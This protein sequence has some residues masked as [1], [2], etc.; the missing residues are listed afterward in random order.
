MSEASSPP[1][2]TTVNIRMT[3]SFLADVDA[4]WK[5]LGYNSRSEFVRDVLRDAVK[6]P[7][8]DRADLKAV[9]ASEVDIQ[10]GRTRDSDAIK[11][12]YGSGDDGDR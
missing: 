12:E 4:T 3:E 5:D 8:F 9:A 10:Q 7:E 1:E 6:H 2:K 11:A